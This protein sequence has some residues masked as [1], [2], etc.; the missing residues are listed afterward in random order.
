MTRSIVGPFLGGAGVLAA[1]ALAAGCAESYVYRPE[2][3]TTISHGRPV[4]RIAIPRERPTGEIRLEALGMSRLETGGRSF[5]ALHLRMRVAN[6]SDTTMWRLDT[7]DQLL[8]IPGEGRSRPIFANSDRQ[9]MPIVMIPQRERRVIDLFYPLPS[10]VRDPDQLQEFEL[11]WR[12]QTSQ[13][14][15][16]ERTAFDRI[17]TEP[18]YSGTFYAGWG[19]YWWY[20]P[21][22]PSFVFVHSRPIV[23]RHPTAVTVSRTPRSVATG[24]RHR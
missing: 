19:P 12:V 14:V 8:E 11:Q 13:R 21:F 16:A 9:A 18:E 17:S 3:A 24:G 7:R 4:T 10:T 20:D 6:D 15:V 2:G 23:V 1:I 22:Y 5:D